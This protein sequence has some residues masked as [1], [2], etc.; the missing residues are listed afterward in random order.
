MTIATYNIKWLSSE[1]AECGNIGVKD[2]R[3]QKDQ[4]GNRLDR[5]RRIIDKLDADM[6]GLQEIRD[7]KALEL[8]FGTDGTWTI[9]INDNSRDCQDLALAVRKPFE[10]VGATD[11]KLNASRDH[12]LFE[13]E[14]SAYFPGSRDI[15]DVEVRLP[16]VTRS[17][18]ILVHHAKSRSGGRAATNGRRVGASRLIL[19]RL[20]QDF[21]DEYFVLMGDFNDNPDD[22]SLNILESGD[23]DARSEMENEPGPF[24]INLTEALGANDA[25]SHGRSWN[26]VEGEIIDVVQPSSREKNFAS[27]YSNEYDSSVDVLFDQ[28][29]VPTNVDRFYVRDSVRVFS[30]RLGVSGRGD[31][32]AS[33]HLPVVADFV[34]PEDR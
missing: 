27:R 24:L 15:L 16:G 1:T 29:L 21:Q 10:V 19:S 22:Q 3:E 23:E 34:F 5:L 31:A 25:V 28:I 11:G 26:D 12:F 18:H 6:I 20:K 32:R 30:H 13:D 4:Y 14:S 8:I 33:D 2:V 9:V 17:L 7:R